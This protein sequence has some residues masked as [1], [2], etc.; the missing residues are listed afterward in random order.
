MTSVAAE[1][2]T[3]E[4]S[5]P[6]DDVLKMADP[7]AEADEISQDV[8]IL[9][10]SI[11]WSGDK[12]KCE[13][14]VKGEVVNISSDSSINIYYFNI[15]L[16]SENNEEE[17][18]FIY[19]HTGFSGGSLETGVITL[20]DNDY[21]S[22]EGTFSFEFDKTHFGEYTEVLDIEVRGTNTNG[23]MDEIKWGEGLPGDDDTIDDDTIDDDATDDDDD[24]SPG[25]SFFLILGSISVVLGVLLF[26]RRRD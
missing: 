12:V 4:R 5:D 9:S 22:S 10:A 14:R 11:D 23:W 13:F 25:F 20:Y 21:S 6:D 2:Q 15:D 3:M 8:E 1:G 17:I 26:R 24:D 16:T 18:F 7:F 19:T